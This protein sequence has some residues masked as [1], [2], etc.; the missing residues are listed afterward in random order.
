MQQTIAQAN[1]IA[2]SCDEVTTI[3]NQSWIYIHAN[4]VNNFVRISLLVSLKRVV[5]GGTASKLAICIMDAMVNHGGISK[6]DLRR[7]FMSFGT[8]GIA[9]MQVWQL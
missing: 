9:V 3:D 6:A 8:D 5:E 4:F 1:Y 2:I 7:K